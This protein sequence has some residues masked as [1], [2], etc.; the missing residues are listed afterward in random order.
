MA[1]S[2]SSETSAD[3]GVCQRPG[4][5]PRRGDGA[6]PRRLRSSRMGGR[7]SLAP[8]PR[9]KPGVVRP[10]I[11]LEPTSETRSEGS[12]RRAVSAERP[13]GRGVDR[14][15]ADGGGGDERIRRAGSG[16]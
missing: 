9:P 11:R 6:A 12:L 16:V 13:M 2:S 1:S 8:P 14:G 4:A 15:A 7:E 10:R 5:L 3:T